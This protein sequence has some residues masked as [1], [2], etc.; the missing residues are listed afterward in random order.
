MSPTEPAG[1]RRRSG[2]IQRAIELERHSHRTTARR[3][4]RSLPVSIPAAMGM[5]L[6]P[7]VHHRPRSTSLLPNLPRSSR[8]HRR[9]RSSSVLC[10]SFRAVSPATRRRSS[11]ATTFHSKPPSLHRRPPTHA[12][13]QDI[14]RKHAKLQNARS[15]AS[16]HGVLP[17]ARAKRLAERRQ[18]DDD[19]TIPVRG[20]Q[21]AVHQTDRL[22][23]PARYPATHG[24]QVE[25]H[26]ADT[27]HDAIAAGAGADSTATGTLAQQPAASSIVRQQEA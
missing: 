7:P 13:P 26:S 21:L 5:V 9:R 11:R 8:R 3:R 22:G 17:R 19:S 23:P 18:Q 27:D 15:M 12:L 6:L 4:S 2:I 14:H 10:F 16:Q 1:V 25:R 24:R 20:V